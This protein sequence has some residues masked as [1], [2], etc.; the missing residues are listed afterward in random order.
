MKDEFRHYIEQNCDAQLLGALSFGVTQAFANLKETIS[1]NKEMRSPEYRMAYGHMRKALVDIALKEIFQSSKIPGNAM[2]VPV[3]NKANASTYLKIQTDGGI[4]LNA[5]TESKGAMPRQA[6][7][8]SKLSQLNR[9][10][11]LFKDDF[12]VQPEIQNDVSMIL[13]YGGFDYGLSYVYL[14]LPDVESKKWISQIDITN[15][16]LMLTM[17][18]KEKAQQTIQ[19]TLT[20]KSKQILEEERDGES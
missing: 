10:F 9:A 11:D 16:P 15:A 7:H 3:N 20:N 18:D 17:P 5:K 1:N 19:M 2:S 8:R 12:E 4:I 13:T 14:G 6:L